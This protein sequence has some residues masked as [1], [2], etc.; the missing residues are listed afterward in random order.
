MQAL[1][2]PG[3]FDA[4]KPVRDYIAELGKGAGLSDSAVYKLCLAVDE[5]ATNVVMHGYEEAGLNGN[6]TVEGGIDCGRLVILL[7]DTGKS[8]DPT[9]HSIPT[10]ENLSLPLEERDIGGLGILLARDGV[11]DLQYEATELGNVHRFIINLAGSQFI[12]DPKVSTLTDE[13][14]KLSILLS[15]SRTLGQEIQ[16]DRLL[17][18]IV[19]EVTSAMEAERSSLLLYDAANGELVKKWR[20]A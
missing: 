1:T 17:T 16:L 18:L 3:D 20:K 9:K 14:R 13:R 12:P 11:D 15:I 5:I 6:L 4:L 19:A 7:H 2:V 10:A 8:Y